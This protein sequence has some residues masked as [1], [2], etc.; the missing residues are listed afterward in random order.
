M[1]GAA[2]IGSVNTSAVV[3]SAASDTE[4][5]THTRPFTQPNCV[6]KVSK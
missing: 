5:H 1:V 2:V 3:D 4:A 6:N